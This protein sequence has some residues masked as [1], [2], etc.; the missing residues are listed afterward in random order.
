MEVRLS[1]KSISPA[2][3]SFQG[4]PKS[5][6]EPLVRPSLFT[7]ITPEI[8]LRQRYRGLQQSQKHHSNDYKFFIRAKSLR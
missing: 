8:K 2:R 5:R 3:H 4:S 6:Y 7:R 1:A